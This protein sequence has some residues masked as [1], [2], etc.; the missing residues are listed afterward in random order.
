MNWNEALR[1]T[2]PDHIV[3]NDDLVSEM[4]VWA[5]TMQPP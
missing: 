4:K 1:P 3:G 5:D 2:Q